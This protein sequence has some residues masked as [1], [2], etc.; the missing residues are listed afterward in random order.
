M[1]RG[2]YTYQYAIVHVTKKSKACSI[3]GHSRSCEHMQHIPYAMH[4]LG[5]MLIPESDDE[6]YDFYLAE[7]ECTDTVKPD[8]IEKEC[9]SQA[10]K[11][12]FH[13]YHLYFC[14]FVCFNQQ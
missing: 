10:T 11:V 1:T 12:W 2:Q 8:D 7:Y 9:V 4:D 14:H 13:F 6:K 3:S 5:E